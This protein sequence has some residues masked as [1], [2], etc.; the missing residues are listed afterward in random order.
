VA[1]QPKSGVQIMMSFVKKQLSGN[2]NFTDFDSELGL[3][4]KTIHTGRC[5][6]IFS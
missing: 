1:A 6:C 2:L 3:S 5:E 4:F